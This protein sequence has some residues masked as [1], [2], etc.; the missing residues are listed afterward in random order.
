MN[1]P[2]GYLVSV[3]GVLR[4]PLTTALSRDLTSR[5]EAE[6]KGDGRL[7]PR[8]RWALRLIDWLWKLTVDVLSNIPCRSVEVRH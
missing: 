7:D 6:R 3:A 8:A 4:R 5:V 2:S 1:L